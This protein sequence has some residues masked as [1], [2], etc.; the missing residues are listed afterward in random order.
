MPRPQFEPAEREPGIVGHLLACGEIVPA[1]L[2]AP[3]DWSPEKRLAGA[4]LAHTLTEIRDHPRD[5]LHHRRRLAEDLEWVA[6][7]DTAWPYSFVPLCELFRLEP[8]Y[9]RRVV[10]RWM[11]ADRAPSQRSR[12]AHRHAA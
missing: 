3:S 5:A 4:V 12:C 6:S 2:P 8:E 1:Q 10:A 7:N 11:Q 9:V